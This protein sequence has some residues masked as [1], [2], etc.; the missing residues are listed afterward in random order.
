MT[1]NNRNRYNRKQN[2][3]KS[4]AINAYGNENKRYSHHLYLLFA[5]ICI[6]PL[7]VRL[8]LY[9][10]KLS[11]FAWYPNN[12]YKEDFF[13]LYKQRFF[14]IVAFFMLVYVIYAV[15]SKCGKIKEGRI[16]IPL[17]VYALLSIL[18]TVFSKYRYYSLTGSYEQFE[19]IFVLL[20]YCI[21]AY[22]TYLVLNEERDFRLIYYSLVILTLILGILGT[23]QFLGYD[24]FYSEL[25][26]KLIIP[27]EFRNLELVTYIPDKVYLTLYNPNYV[28]MLGS[29]LIPVLFIMTLMY[30]RPLWTILSILSIISFTVSVAGSRSLS[31]IIAIAAAFVCIIIFM[32]R[33]L[34]KYIYVTVSVV[35]IL[36][37]GVFLI[38]K[39]TDHYFVNKMKVAINIQKSVPNLESIETKDD[40]VTIIYKGNEMNLI[41]GINSDNTAEIAAFDDSY[42]YINGEY[43]F[44]TGVYTVTDERFAG[45]KYGFD[46][47][48]NGVFY[49]EIEGKRW[50]FTNR[51]EDG[52]YYFVNRFNKLDKMSDAPAA[53]K[54]YDR[55][56]SNRGYIWSKT[57]PLLKNTLFLGSGPD[58]FVFEFPQNDYLGFFQNGFESSIMTKPHNL[59][60]QIAVQ[61]GVLSL[62]AFLAFYIWYF[63]SSIR[64][65]IRGRFNSFYSRMGLAIFIGTIGYMIAGLT[66]DSSIAIAPIFW[67]MIGAGIAVNRKA[68]PLI[69]A[70]IAEKK[71]QKVKNSSNDSNDRK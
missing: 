20:G 12:K 33:Y 10:P 1:Q 22:Y 35:V 27:Y 18:S 26:K 9:E 30:R 68:K 56:A 6:L 32:W 62:I 31:G 34:F 24:F 58:T 69:L 36:F 59:Y 66:N 37:L 54:G 14:L 64:L 2:Q 55:F 42:R 60:L 43:N 49:A 23:F 19:S 39:Y 48:L 13:L 7:I 61:T 67:L 29:L 47:Q 53:F 4:K 25:G 17:A 40:R 15:V 65:Y 5:V 52:T 71:T 3:S 57:L 46:N 28:G 8:A 16:F 38:D 41:Y 45:I 70:E 63:I 51:T 11:D 44:D 21:T 50:R